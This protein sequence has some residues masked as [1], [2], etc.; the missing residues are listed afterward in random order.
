MIEFDHVAITV[1]NLE[2]S[3]QFYEKLGYQLQYQFSDKEYR[4]ATLKLGE[5]SLELF[6]PLTKEVP[7]IEHLAYSFTQ[8]E[9]A[10]EL[11]QKLGTVIDQSKLFYG[12]LNR[13]SFFLEQDDG[14]SIQFIK[15]I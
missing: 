9:E 14:M 15:K 2:T 7:K 6:E 3:I 4:W 5:S 1:N 13:K 12:D 8:D 11:A 10:L